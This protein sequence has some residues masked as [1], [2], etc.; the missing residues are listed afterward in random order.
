MP[1]KEE[2]VPP[3]RRK[4][5]QIISKEGLQEVNIYLHNGESYLHN[6]ILC[7]DSANVKR[8]FNVLWFLCALLI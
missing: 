3:V 1:F 5:F 4:Q 8:K 2:S 6:Q 7:K